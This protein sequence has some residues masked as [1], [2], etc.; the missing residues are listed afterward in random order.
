MR[1][2]RRV[3]NDVAA[4]A[5]PATAAATFP[6]DTAPAIDPRHEYYLLPPSYGRGY[7]L[8][9]LGRKVEQDCCSYALQVG[10]HKVRVLL[11]KKCYEICNSPPATAQCKCSIKQNGKLTVGCIGDIEHAWHIVLGVLG[12]GEDGQP[13]PETQ[14]GQPAPETQKATA[15]RNEWD[16]STKEYEHEGDLPTQIM[17]VDEKPIHHMNESLSK[18]VSTLELE[19]APTVALRA[20]HFACASSSTVGATAARTPPVLP[21]SIGGVR[22]VDSHT[23]RCLCAISFMRKSDNPAVA[24]VSETPEMLCEGSVKKEKDGICLDEAA[25]DVDEDPR[26]YVVCGTEGRL[27]GVNNGHG[28]Q[29]GPVHFWRS[30]H[31]TVYAFLSFIAQGLSKS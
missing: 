22:I 28:A 9:N 24:E 8:V 13:L 19:S 14:D 16:A 7:D 25:E 10:R 11:K 12:I 27:C 4:A 20:S 29:V 6:R 26:V 30:P 17:N 23:N 21:G 5:A 3:A 1:V 31:G 15:D 18:A 2:R